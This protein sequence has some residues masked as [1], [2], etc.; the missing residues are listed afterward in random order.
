MKQDYFE[1]QGERYNTGDT[2]YMFWYGSNV[3]ISN[4]TKA[5][6]ISYDTETKIYTFKPNGCAETNFPED[7]FLKSLCLRTRPNDQNKPKEPRKATIIDELNIDGMI[8]A[9]LWYIFVMVAGVIIKDCII[10][11]VF[12]SIIF[13]NYRN[14]KLREAGFKK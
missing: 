9:W 8:T 6:F 13:F 11:W 12:T 3:G 7:I 4:P 14:K 10:L 5:I 1:Y 2:F